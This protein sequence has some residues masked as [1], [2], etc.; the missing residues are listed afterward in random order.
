MYQI[1]APALRAVSTRGGKIIVAI[2]FALFVLGAIRA[3]TA[4]SGR[5]PPLF[6]LALSFLGTAAQA[7]DAS[8]M[9][10]NAAV[11]P[12]NLYKLA[13]AKSDD[14]DAVLRVYES[15]KRPQVREVSAILKG[16]SDADETDLPIVDRPMLT[17]LAKYGAQEQR[18]R[19]A[20][21]KELLLHVL[22]QIVEAYEPKL[23]GK[24]VVKSHLR[25]K[26]RLQSEEA[27]ELLKIMIGLLRRDDHWESA[28][29]HLR[30][31]D[32]DNDGGWAKLIK[33][34]DELRYVENVSSKE[35]PSF[36]KDSAIPQLQWALG[37]EDKFIADLFKKAAENN[38]PK[39]A[40]QPGKK[41][42]LKSKPEKTEAR[43]EGEPSSTGQHTEKPKPKFKRPDFL[44]KA[45]EKAA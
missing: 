32:P 45:A 22:I 17:G 11:S 8:L 20:R 35:L 7:D 38:A 37:L 40:S 1:T 4:S 43:A 30:L 6:A 9:K 3:A 29:G 24:A 41:A 18:V 25:E 36:L 12:T 28:I 21:L 10:S 31:Q 26:I 23:R 5:V 33:L 44:K 14:I 2:I 27:H 16:P 34:L 15:G 19:I 39:A 13:H 42:P